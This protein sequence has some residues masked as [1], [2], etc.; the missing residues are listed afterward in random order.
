VP[1][2]SFFDRNRQQLAERGIDPSR[3]PPGQYSTDRFPVL[4]AGGVPE[5]TSLDAWTLAL[6]GLVDRQVTLTWAQ[7]AG[8]P[9]VEVVTDIHCVTKWSK[10]DTGWRGV[11]FD[12]L[13]EQAGGP[14]AGAT[15]LLCSSEF[16]YTANVPLVDCVGTDEQGRP[17]AMVAFAYD[18]KPLEPEHGYPARFLVPHLYF[19]KSA[20]WLRGLELLPSD[21]PGFWERN[22]YHMYGDPFREQRFSGD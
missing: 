14:A 16:G 9:S 17:R 22:G 1:P 20:K 4:H 7:L 3:L 10:F 2:L 21:R 19:W 11:A 6:S 5:Y 13:L 15:H 18:G 12:T 8:L